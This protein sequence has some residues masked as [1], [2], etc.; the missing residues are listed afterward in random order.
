M[1]FDEFSSVITVSDNGGVGREPRGA[2]RI[3][4]AHDHQLMR[5][6]LRALLERVPEFSVVGEVAD[7]R[8]A[9]DGI[10]RLAP[11]ILVLDDALPEPACCEIARRIR[12]HGGATRVL[13]LSSDAD[14]SAP[15]WGELCHDAFR[16]ESTAADLVRVIRATATRRHP[17][18][19]ARPP[20]GECAGDP[21]DSLTPR[22]REVLQLAAEGLGNVAIGRRLRISPRTVE[23]HRAHLMRKMAFRGLSDVIRYGVKRGLLIPNEE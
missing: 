12:E 16:K 11:D 15:S 3:L 19:P 17:G 10:A 20:G 6:A 22:E 1:H 7:G 4:I 5:H 18:D 13:L 9:A 23:T 2:I 21:Y 8:A 14:P